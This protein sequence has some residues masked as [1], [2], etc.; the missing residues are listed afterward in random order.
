[1]K[2]LIVEDDETTARAIKTYLQHSGFDVALACT[3][4]QAIAAAHSEQPHL[5]ILD[6]M[7]P[8]LSGIDVCRA[9]RECGDVPIIML[10]ARTMEEDKLAGL[11][12]GA[13][14][15]VTKPFSPRELV[16]R[17]KSVLRRAQ[18]GVNHRTAS[19]GDLA[20]DWTARVAS[21]RGR[22]LAL[23][24]TEFRLLDALAAAPS[25][26]LSRSA[27]VQKVF[28][29]DY[30]GMERTLDVH[31]RNVRKKIAEAG[32]QPACIRTVFGIGYVFETSAGA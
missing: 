3:G 14:D 8:E 31:V 21:I 11:T 7:L 18:S 2:I 25:V 23:T 27:L 32:G 29:Y 1:M 22:A 15:Y 6:V 28:G 12:A 4:P 17:V 24:P 30:D 16:A 13:D 9:L 26:P 10:T 5:V 20:I 19:F